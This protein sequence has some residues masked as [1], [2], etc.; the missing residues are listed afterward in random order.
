MY[1]INV[2]VVML[3]VILC[4]KHMIKPTLAQC[5]SFQ[6]SLFNTCVNV[7]L[8]RNGL[9]RTSPLVGLDPHSRI[10]W[11]L[12]KRLLR[13]ESRAEKK[14]KGLWKEESRWERV[15][16]VLRSNMLVSSVK[17]LFKWTSGT[18]EK[19]NITKTLVIDFEICLVW[20][21]LYNIYPKSDKGSSTI[22]L[23]CDKCPCVIITLCLFTQHE[24]R[25]S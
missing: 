5:F 18:K 11:S 2:T 13:A 6:G 12:Y 10:Y 21:T 16:D 24:D 23:S 8:L 9:A 15:T 7:D 25:S 4:L 20:C 22:K 3:L 19:W 17:R 1:N 14:G